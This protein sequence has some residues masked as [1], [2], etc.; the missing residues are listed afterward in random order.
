MGTYIF[1]YISSKFSSSY[2][3]WFIKK[4]ISV[5]VFFFDIE[6]D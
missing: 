2:W 3:I 1:I 6:S 5:L 4:C